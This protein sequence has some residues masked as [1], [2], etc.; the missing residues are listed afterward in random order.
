MSFK[1]K[2]EKV[3]NADT[4]TIVNVSR[5]AAGEYKCSL[6][7]NPML[8]ASVDIKVNCKKPSHPNTV[9]VNIWN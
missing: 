1:D 3:E 4:Y 8:E 7:D 5:D 6:I 9:L 2:M